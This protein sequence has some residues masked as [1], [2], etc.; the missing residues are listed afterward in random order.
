MTHH[1]ITL[2]NQSLSGVTSQMALSDTAVT[3]V[4]HNRRTGEQ[5]PKNE[6][7]RHTMQTNTQKRGKQVYQVESR[8]NAT[9]PLSR[10]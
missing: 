10:Y 2:V 5:I 7:N 3:P 1:L 4:T 8:K 9:Y 6:A